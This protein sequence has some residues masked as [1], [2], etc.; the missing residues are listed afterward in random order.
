MNIVDRL[1]QTE[2]VV[3]ETAEEREIELKRLSKLMGEPFILRCKGLPG[4]R[5]TE[6]A[7]IAVDK[8]GKPDISKAH[9]VNILIAVA[10][11]ISP[12]L[13]DQRLLQHFK[14]STPKDLICKLLNGGEI[15]RVAEAVTEL[16]GFGEDSD[17][18][19]KN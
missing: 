12:D 2:P 13:K 15:A 16:S 8:N 1:L 10:G 14:C 9:D 7:T 3:L 4:N 18:E 17:D 6:L 19:I 5:Y 11:T